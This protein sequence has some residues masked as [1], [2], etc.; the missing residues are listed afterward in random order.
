MH[1]TEAIDTALANA[2]RLAKSARLFAMTMDEA[3][4]KL[5]ASAAT[6]TALRHGR[7]E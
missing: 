3:T 1:A 7:G 4:T 6:M 2:K 5:E